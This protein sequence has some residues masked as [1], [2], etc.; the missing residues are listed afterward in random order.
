MSKHRPQPALVPGKV[1]DLP[2]PLA[3]WFVDRPTVYQQCAQIVNNAMFPC[4][5]TP[6]QCIVW[7]SEDASQEALSQV[8]WFCRY[9]GVWV[10]MSDSTHY[11]LLE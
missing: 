5:V 3:I 10:E 6:L 1:Q 8:P 2:T 11:R 4:G 7:S 9:P